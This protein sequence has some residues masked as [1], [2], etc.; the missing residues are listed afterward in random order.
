[1]RGAGAEAEVVG[2]EEVRVTRHKNA[3]ALLCNNSIILYIY[4]CLQ[5]VRNPNLKASCT[6]SIRPHT[7][8]A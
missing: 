5:Q 3:V 2:E 1:V 7:L 8:I 4:S 6:S